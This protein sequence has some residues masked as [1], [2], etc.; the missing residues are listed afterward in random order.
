MPSEDGLQDSIERTRQAFRAAPEAPP[1]IPR[2]DNAP[3]LSIGPASAPPGLHPFFRGL[4]EALPAPGTT[5]SQ[6][7]RDQWLETAR[8]IFAL[9]YSDSEVRSS[10]HP[11]ASIQY[12][13]A[14]RSV[15]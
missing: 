8:N 6:V 12:D 10:N 7:Q 14:N 9:L 13:Q 15:S 3:P 2:H 5:W 4:L 1:L 11:P